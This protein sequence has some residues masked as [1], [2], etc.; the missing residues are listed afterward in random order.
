MIC[1]LNLIRKK[2]EL[3]FSEINDF[4]V[5]YLT[6]R[7]KSKTFNQIYLLRNNSKKILLIKLLSEGASKRIGNKFVELVNALLFISTP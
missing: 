5:E 2:I 1:L 3:N 7:N 4:E 6:N